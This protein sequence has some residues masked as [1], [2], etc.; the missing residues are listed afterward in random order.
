MARAEARFPKPLLV[1]NWRAESCGADGADANLIAILADRADLSAV[2]FC[3]HIRDAASSRF[4]EI[5]P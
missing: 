2:D 3:A 1:V 5:A 4:C